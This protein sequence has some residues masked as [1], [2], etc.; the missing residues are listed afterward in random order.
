MPTF[1]LMAIRKDHVAAA[2]L[3]I[4]LLAWGHSSGELHTHAAKVFE[5]LTTA[6]VFGALWECI[7]RASRLLV[8]LL[9]GR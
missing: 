4:V 2:F 7:L 1:P 9:L 3:G 5:V 8:G 6:L